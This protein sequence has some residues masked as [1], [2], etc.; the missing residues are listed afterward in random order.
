MTTNRP[1]LK[2]FL[3][4][5]EANTLVYIDI[6]CGFIQS[7]HMIIPLSIIFK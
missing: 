3:S 5:I 7:Y 6:K 4:L 2:V 1:T